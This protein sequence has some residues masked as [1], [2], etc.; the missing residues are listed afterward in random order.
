[1]ARYCVLHVIEK[2]MAYNV[3][4]K[5]VGVN[6]LALSALRRSRQLQYRPPKHID[7]NGFYVRLP[8]YPA[9]AIDAPAGPAAMSSV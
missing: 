2:L 7:R 8:G 4:P 5:Y 9:P 3:F 1:M 6:I